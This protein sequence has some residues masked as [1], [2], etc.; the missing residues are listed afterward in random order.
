MVSD[1]VCH[2]H[3]SFFLKGSFTP[4]DQLVDEHTI[5]VGYANKKKAIKVDGKIVSTYKDI[6]ELFQVVTLLEDD[7]N[8]IKGYPAQRRSFMDQSVL[9]LRTGY[10]KEFRDFKRILQSRNALLSKGVTDRL[11][12]DIWTEKLWNHSIQISMHRSEVL[13]KVEKVMNELLK[14]YFDDIYKITIQYESKHVQ[15]SENFHDFK[16]R[17]SYIFHQESFIKR[18]QFGAHLDDFIVKIDGRN[19]RLYASRGQQ[20]LIALL[21]KL[22]LISLANKNAFSPVILVDDFIADFDSKRLKNIVKFFVNCKNQVIITTPCY[23]T[24][25]KRIVEIADPDVLSMN[26]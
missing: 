22:S 9:F 17:M 10:L 14:T 2:D 25:L 3:D 15:K 8:L 13:Q 7:I 19:A 26:F 11:E 23:D 18:S 20:K 12:L 21:C 5:Q 6:F 1:L 16:Q 4:T 24:D